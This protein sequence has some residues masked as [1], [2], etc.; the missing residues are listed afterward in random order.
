MSKLYFDVTVRLRKSYHREV[1]YREVV[2]V[3]TDKR[4][5]SL[6]IEDSLKQSAEMLAKIERRS[7][8]NLI[9]FLLQE[10]VEDAKKQGR[11]PKGDRP[12]R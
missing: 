12:V 9:E 1:F 10:A 11:L 3:P 7:L 2:A 5:V 6:Y 8:N 4:K